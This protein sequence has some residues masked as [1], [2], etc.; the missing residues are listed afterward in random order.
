MNGVKFLK[1]SIAFILILIISASACA[2]GSE[3]C[4]AHTDANTDG[5][6][7]ACSQKA[8]AYIDVYSIS[9]ITADQ[10]ISKL[11]NYIRQVGGNEN[12][13]ILSTGNMWLDGEER[14][15]W[16]DGLGFDAMAVGDCELSKGLNALESDAKG[17]KH[18]LLAINV[19]DRSTKTHADF[20]KPSVI[21]ERDGARIGIIGAVAAETS[22][23]FYIR[24][25]NDL[26]SLVKAESERLRNEENADII[27]Y[28]L[29]DG[30][31][32]SDTAFLQKVSDGQIKSYY[33]ISLSEGYVDI[34]F[35]GK[36]GKAYRLEDRHGIYHLQNAGGISY[37]SI[38]VNI[39]DNNATI[40][41]TKLISSDA[42]LPPENPEI[43]STP[44]IESSLD[45]SDNDSNSDNDNNV[46]GKHTD[47]NSDT[48]CDVCDES[49]IVYFD[50]YTIN[51]LHGKLADSDSHVGVD[52]LSTFLKNARKTDQNAIFL[53]AGDMWQGSSE[54]N[55]TKGLIITDW[56]NELDFTA[57]TLGN[58]EYDWGS[59]Y[60]GNNE[61]LAEFPFLA[62]N[63]YERATNKLAPYCQPSVT[64]EADGLQIGIIGAMGDCYSS[65][66]TDKSDDVYFKVGAQLTALVKEES[67][68]L[69]GEGVDFI[70]Y[71]IHDGY[72]SSHYGYTKQVSSSQISGY[73]DI[74]LSDGYID[75]VFEGHTHQGY[76]LQDEHGV[77]HLQNRGDNKGGISHAEVAINSVTNSAEVEVA[78]L[79]ST[80]AYSG[81]ADDPVVKKL[82]EKYDELI[83]PA[84]K[85]LGYNKTYRNSNYLCQL[86]ADLYYDAG[87]EKWGDEYDIVLGGGYLSTRSPYNLY[88]GEIMYSDLQSLFP[89]DNQLALC[90]IK[91][92]YLKSKFFETNNND[93]FICYDE[94]GS[95][96]KNSINANATY[97]VVVDTYTAYY[98][99]NRLTVI[100]LYD[101]TTFARDLLADHVEAGG[102][103]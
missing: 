67:E 18:P 79:I 71:V 59:E 10:P 91:G 14:I 22:E 94:Y 33:D 51:D 84:N 48:V 65:I 34:V 96:I 75:L 80:S 16:M 50:F 6:C 24:T 1:K 56:M 60:I 49:V 45:T 90:S 81:L 95:S 99:P 53:S 85:V 30:Y 83:S 55:M 86:V 7:D 57:M 31:G 27:I 11:E 97:Y 32:R 93:Y 13:L 26:T 76:L 9:D 47:K 72:G 88:S 78:E 4:S 102:L 82:L 89:F 37:A 20:C 87:V 62:I 28:L 61:K 3:P 25:G 92:S 63:V 8:F 58:H 39:A 40:S 43:E 38:A 70:V 66:A 23:D 19:Y 103:S 69:R 15:A 73:Y 46:C 42:E 64:V 5:I 2:C 101:E 54:S 35:E 21:L 44:D 100:E 17:A 74:S 12:T 68:R 41:S 29:H 77:Y 52:E 36:T 98:A